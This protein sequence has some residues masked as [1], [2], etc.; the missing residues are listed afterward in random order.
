MDC[1]PSESLLRR[2]VFDGSRSTVATVDNTVVEMEGFASWSASILSGLR[3]V[4]R[5]FVKSVSE[6]I[7]RRI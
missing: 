5:R 3:V 1:A 4:A 7:V 2:T 6:T